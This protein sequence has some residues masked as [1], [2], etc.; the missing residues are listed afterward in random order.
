MLFQKNKIHH[1]NTIVKNNTINQGG[2]V[3]FEGVEG[4]EATEKQVSENWNPS[5]NYHLEIWNLLRVWKN[6]Y[7]FRKL[8]KKF[9]SNFERIY[10]NFLKKTYF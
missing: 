9:L 7:I 1:K 3:K 8:K 2:E 5:G 10:E 6:K 4:D